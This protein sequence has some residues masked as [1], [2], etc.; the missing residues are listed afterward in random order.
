MSPPNDRFL[1]LDNEDRLGEA[2]D[3]DYRANAEWWLQCGLLHAPLLG[4][5]SVTAEDAAALA[6]RISSHVHEIGWQ[7]HLH[8]W[9]DGNG[10]ATRAFVEF[11]KGG[12][13]GVVDLR[14]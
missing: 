12:G 4:A 14:N 13:F 1:Y 8:I 2:L 10:T 7:C 6:D 11:L 3:S 5:S 9:G